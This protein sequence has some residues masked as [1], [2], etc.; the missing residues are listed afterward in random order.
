MS[1]NKESG[2]AIFGGCTR[3]ILLSNLFPALFCF[4]PLNIEGCYCSSFDTEWNFVFLKVSSLL[5]FLLE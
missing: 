1:L 2:N 5:M 4:Q 3:S